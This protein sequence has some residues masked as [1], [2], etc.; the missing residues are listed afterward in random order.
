MVISICFCFGAFTILIEN[1]TIKNE[2]SIFC[3]SCIPEL[4]LSKVN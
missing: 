3:T 4:K 2:R 1:T